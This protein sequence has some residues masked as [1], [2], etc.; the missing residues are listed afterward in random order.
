MNF[1]D[2]ILNKIDRQRFQKN[3]LENSEMRSRYLTMKREKVDAFRPSMDDFVDTI[4]GGQEEIDQDKR[5]VALRKREFAAACEGDVEMQA[6]HEIAEIYEGVLIDQ[7][8][9]S[10]WFGSRC[11]IQVTSE[12]DD[13]KHGIDG[14]GIFKNEDAASDYIGFGIDVTFASDIKILTKKLESIKAVVREKEIT[15][16]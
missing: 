9:K 15:F 10:E 13:I 7:I 8:E 16:C 5:E 2:T 4:P 12:Y 1:E 3:I 14:V 6:V 11:T